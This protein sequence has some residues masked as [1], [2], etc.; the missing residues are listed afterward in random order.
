MES[1]S[2]Q[3]SP[4]PP[5]GEVLFEIYGGGVPSTSL[6]PYS[7]SDQICNFPHPI[8]DLTL[9]NVPLSSQNDKNL[10]P[11]SDKQAKH[12][13]F[14]TSDQLESVSYFGRCS[15]ILYFSLDFIF[16]T[17]HVHVLL[18]LFLYFTYFILKDLCHNNFKKVIFTM[19]KITS[20]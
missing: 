12:T 14:V 3:P 6:N 1:L 4:P 7:F 5:P 9:R 15:H 10:Y 8:S 17:I 18:I 19:S 11:I 16:F 20:N 13:Q 2:K